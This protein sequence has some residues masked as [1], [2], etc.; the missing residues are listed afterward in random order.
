[1]KLHGQKVEGP[2]IELI[3]IPRGGDRPDIILKA[4][5]VV[6][7]TPFDK[8]CPEPLAPVRITKGGVKEYQ[9]E[10]AGYKAAIEAR[11]QKYIAW[12]VIES[13]KAT[14]GLEWDL[15]KLDDHRSWLKYTDELKEAGF[16]HV[17]IQRIINGVFRANCLD[18]AKIEEARKSFLR[19]NQEQSEKSSGLPT[20]QENS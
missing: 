6:D 16:S 11:S 2:N 20:A 19:G 12:M 4:Q 13:L 3:V 15:V 9:L 17:E 18:E 10:D 14:E 5:A 8:M 1:M 7:R